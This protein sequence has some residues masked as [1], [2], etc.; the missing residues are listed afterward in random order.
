MSEQISDLEKRGKLRVFLMDELENFASGLENDGLPKREINI[1]LTLHAAMYMGHSNEVREFYKWWNEASAKE[2]EKAVDLKPIFDKLI[3]VAKEGK[4]EKAM[5][6][7]K[8]L[9]FAFQLLE[10]DWKKVLKAIEKYG[11]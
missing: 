3:S 9:L 11:R 7:Y 8:C 10:P 6:I 4:V 5:I 2:R 1:S